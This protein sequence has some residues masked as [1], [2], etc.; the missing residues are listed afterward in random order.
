[1]SAATPAS[2]GFVVTPLSEVGAAEIVGLDCARPFDAQTLAAVEA[3]FL[4]YPI[5]VFRDQILGAKEQAA[6]SRQ[7]GALEPQDRLH[8]THPDDRDVLILSNEIGPDG[9]PV[10]VVDAGDFWHSDSSHHE[11]PVKSTILYAVK[12]PRTGGDT[13]Y[14]NMYLVY[15]ALPDELRDAVAGRTAVHHVSKARNPRVSISKDRP[16]AKDY[17][18]AAERI[19]ADVHQPVIRTHPESLR[20]AV[21]VSPRFTLSI[22]GIDAGESERLL[23]AIFEIM[24]RPAFQYR[25]RWRDNDL[26]MWDNR[27]LTHRATGGYV[28]PD[29]RRMHRTTVRG[30]RPFYRPD[31]ESRAI[32]R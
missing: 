30:D 7:F 12:N 20:Q 13:A 31:S 19:H 16:D 29:V 3:A 18:A 15:D 1:M 5:L 27:C 10:G 6:F 32:Q 11:E 9:K 28:L 25:H 14:C 8:Y 26:V 22:D 21:Y 24:K 4:R 17:Y 23:C 2:A